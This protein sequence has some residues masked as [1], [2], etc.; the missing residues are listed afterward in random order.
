MR[1]AC[2]GGLT[3]R[4]HRLWAQDG[5]RNEVYK[6]DRRREQGRRR[7]VSGRVRRYEVRMRSEL[8]R[9][10]APQRIQDDLHSL[11]SNEFERGDKSESPVAATTARKV[12]RSARRAISRPMRMST[13]FCVRSSSKSS[14]VSC[15]CSVMSLRA[16]RGSIRA[17]LETD[18]FAHTQ[19][20]MRLRRQLVVERSAQPKAFCRPPD[21]SEIA[22]PASSPPRVVRLGRSGPRLPLR[23]NPSKT[24]L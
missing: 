5:R 11:P 18:R 7:G 1:L 21:S 20:E 16:I 10:I 12:F 15:L 17:C 22:K 6:S 23:R 14:S 13:A 19:R 8:G 3:E 24:L 4:V 2:G 9:D